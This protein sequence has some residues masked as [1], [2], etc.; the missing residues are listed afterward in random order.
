MVCGKNFGGQ[1]ACS[2]RL[3]V[4]YRCLFSH[5]D[6]SSQ[7]PAL[8]MAPLPSLD[9]GFNP[10]IGGALGSYTL[11]LIGFSLFS[12]MPGLRTF[13][14]ERLVYLSREA[15]SGLSPSG[16]A[17]GRILW[18]M[19]LSLILYPFIFVGFYYLLTNFSVGRLGSYGLTNHNHRFRTS[20]E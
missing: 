16:Y 15:P 19:T 14:T 11:A 7:S 20:V 13:G 3:P 4:S 9:Q 6:P 1:A 12:C 17:L 8:S 5:P 10:S 18:D 2:S